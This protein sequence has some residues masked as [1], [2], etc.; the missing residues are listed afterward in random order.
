[1]D[2]IAYVADDQPTDWVRKAIRQADQLILQAY[3]AAVPGLSPVEG[4]ALAAHPPI[5]RRLIRIHDRRVP[6]SAGT[7]DWLRERECGMWHHVSLEDDRDFKS[8]YRFLTGRA[9]GFV[10][11]GG[12][13]AGSA[14]LVRFCSFSRRGVSVIIIGGRDVR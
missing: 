8:L 5:H 14:P 4:I 7:E 3:G 10:A 2:L 6:F 9:V 11:G 12:G 1:Y 13:G